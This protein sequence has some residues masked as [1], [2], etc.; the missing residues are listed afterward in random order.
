MTV[1]DQL[2]RIATVN[3]S[4]DTGA[5]RNQTSSP[6]VVRRLD[7]EERVDLD[8][9]EGTSEASLAASVPRVSTDALPTQE[10]GPGPGRTHGGLR[11]WNRDGGSNKRMF[12]AHQRHTWQ[13]ARRTA[14]LEPGRRQQQKDV[15]GPASPAI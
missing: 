2:R 10:P 5:R 7:L 3:K 9:V 14:R 12:K 1:N 11:G 15:A 8:N 4:C 13:D 6:M